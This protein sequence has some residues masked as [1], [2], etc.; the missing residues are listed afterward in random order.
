MTRRVLR[1]FPAAVTCAALCGACAV[2]QVKEV[3]MGT[4]EADQIAKQM[5]LITD[6]EV[7]RYIN[8]LG[9]SLAKVTD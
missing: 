7:V 8:V 4:S 3:Q 5:P 1:A 6:P 2:S 9:D